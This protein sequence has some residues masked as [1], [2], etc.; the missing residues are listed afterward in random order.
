MGKERQEVKIV[1]GGSG[2]FSDQ[3]GR[4]EREKKG[5]YKATSATQR[6]TRY[7]TGGGP[8]TRQCLTV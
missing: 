7:N 2:E 5:R 8:V 3:E 6:R 4:E 1:M